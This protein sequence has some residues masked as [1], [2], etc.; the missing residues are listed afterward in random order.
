MES[1]LQFLQNTLQ[2]LRD[3][4]SLPE[5]PI[6]LMEMSWDAGAMMTP[7]GHMQCRGCIDQVLLALMIELAVRALAREW[8]LA[9]PE[10]CL[11]SLKLV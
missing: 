4:T 11:G 3:A 7:C 9:S 5:C 8:G 10:T 2:Q 6:C 1:S